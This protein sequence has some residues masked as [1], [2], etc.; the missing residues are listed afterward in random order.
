LLGLFKK[1]YTVRKHQQQEIKKGYASAAYTDIILRLNVQPL[2][3][4][5]IL[6][7]PEGERTVKRI[8][9]FGVGPMESADEY[10]N[11]PGDR[12]FY[13][14]IWYE[15]VSSVPWDHTMLSHYR[16][17]FV[18]LPANKQPEPPQPTPPPE[19]PPDPDPEEPDEEV[20]E[21]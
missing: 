7:L 21:P 4:N 14:G 17:E 1:S 6:A 15:C 12:L 16:S 10:G 13:R 3:P 19:P 8:K 9:S 2:T 18:A 11:V 20:A 5:E